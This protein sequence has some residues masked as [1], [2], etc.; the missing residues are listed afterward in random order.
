V[1]V[2]I[3][4]ALVELYDRLVADPKADVAQ[5]GYCAANAS[6]VLVITRGGRI[7]SAVPLGSQQGSRDIPLKLKVPD[8]V[9][10]T[11]GDAANFLCDNAEY[12]LG[13]QGGEISERSKRRFDLARELHRRVL[14]PVADEGAQAVLTFF[15]SWKPEDYRGNEKLEQVSDVL[16]S[17]GNIVFRVEGDSMFVHE[18]SAIRRAWE[19]YKASTGPEVKVGQCLIT[20]DWGPIARLHKSISGIAGS[21]TAQPTLVSFNFAAA[22]SYGKSQG[23][24]SP[25]GERAAFAYATAL[26]WLTT[27]ERHR[28]VMGDTTVVFWAE[29]TGPEE[30]L[31]LDVL[32]CAVGSYA[33]NEPEGGAEGVD[34]T[35]DSAH[36]DEESALRVRSVLER[37]TRGQAVTEDMIGF[38]QDLRFFVLGLAPNVARVT[39]RSWNANTFG[40]LLEHVRQHF[41]D[42]A[43]VAPEVERP[44]SAGR[45]LWETV[46]AAS[47]RKRENVPSGFVGP[48]MRAIL[49][50]SMYPHSLYAAVLERVRSDSND[51]EVP[52]V[53]RKVTYP[54]AAY[55]KA[56]LKRKARVT[57]NK[58][59]EEALTAMLNAENKN[60]GYLLGRLFALLEKAQQDANPGIN[61]TIKDRY[62]A[63]ASAT[64]G[65]VFPVLLRLAQHHI[66]KSEYG[67]YVD[68]LIE[69]VLRDLDCF[70]AHLNLDDQGLFA[71]GYY[72]Q[73]DA[74]YRKAEH[75]S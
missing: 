9:K 42:V 1:G 3:L 5:P 27:N 49:E 56:Y 4:N 52:R 73:K 33:Q 40:A 19:L 7:T 14:G 45:L 38:D 35:K 37:I 6:V 22:E 62:Y 16:S 21:K 2:L 15:D 67:G 39:V 17:G 18:R 13:V 23:N 68:R 44:V 43:L 50:G 46:P 63:S 41:S 75:L 29:R 54:R 36:N 31:L 58:T 51:P 32:A 30:D 34:A 28:M 72:H 74:L 48:L 60:R 12:F 71:L 47:R 59:L 55:I 24:N 26:N 11:S 61:T 64:P 70:P 69:D 10:R 20:G 65:T 57:G 66:A 25:V 53:E 8:R